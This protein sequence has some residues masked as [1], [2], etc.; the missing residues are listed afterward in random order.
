MKALKRP[1]CE[2][3]RD[4]GN[5]RVMRLLPRK[6]ADRECNQPKRERSVLQSAKLERQSHLSL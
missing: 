5:A 6:A 1:L 2:A 3:V 4:V